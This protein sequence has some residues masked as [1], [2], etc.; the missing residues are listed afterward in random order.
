M[1]RIEEMSLWER[2]YFP[3]VIRGLTV[4]GYRFLAELD[5]PHFAETRFGKGCPSRDHGA[6]SRRATALSG[7]LPRPPPAHAR[8]MMARCS[9][10]RVFFAPLLVPRSAFI[11]KRASIRTIRWKNIP[12][13]TRSTPCAV[14]TA[15]FASRRVPATRSEWIPERIRAISGLAAENLL[16]PK[17]S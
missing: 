15:V 4:T 5:D 7:Y 10:R 17:K 9:A 11:S 1:K 16:R 3:E 13:G 14:S 8:K 12:S 6:I 2:L